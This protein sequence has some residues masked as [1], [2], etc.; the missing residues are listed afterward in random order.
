MNCF[1]IFAAVTMHKKDILFFQKK[2]LLC[3]YLFLHV[4]FFNMLKM[5]LHCCLLDLLGRL[6]L[7]ML[8]RGQLG[9]LVVRFLNVSRSCFL[10]LDLNSRGRFL[11][12]R[13]GN[14]SGCGLF[15]LNGFGNFRFGLWLGLLFGSLEGRP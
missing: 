6:V 14:G 5:M 10:Q 2:I 13:L 8:Q 11:F 3:S 4:F 12:S 1:K 7:H 9:L 15:Q